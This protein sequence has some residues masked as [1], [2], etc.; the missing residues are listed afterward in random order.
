MKDRASILEA[1]LW[2]KKVDPEEYER[3]LNQV[4]EMDEMFTEGSLTEQVWDEYGPVPGCFHTL[5]A[6]SDE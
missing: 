3:Y 6:P 1:F 5:A 4:F 2:T